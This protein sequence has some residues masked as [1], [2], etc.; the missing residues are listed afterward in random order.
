M[1][2]LAELPLLLCQR[3]AQSLIKQYVIGREANPSSYTITEETDPQ[4]IIPRGT[5]SS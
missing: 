2:Y 5:C 1:V 3:R 4:L